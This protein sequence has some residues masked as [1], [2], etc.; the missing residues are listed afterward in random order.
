M[1]MMK[2]GEVVFLDVRSN[3]VYKAI[4]SDMGQIAWVSAQDLVEPIMK[5]VNAHVE[6]IQPVL[7]E[8]IMEE[9]IN[10]QKQLSSKRPPTGG[11]FESEEDV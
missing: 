4:I 11:S 2:D 8:E 1:P 6:A 9:T 10:T 7:P 5:E 3:E